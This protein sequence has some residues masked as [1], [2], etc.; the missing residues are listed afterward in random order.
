VG[1]RLIGATQIRPL[2]QEINLREDGYHFEWEFSVVASNRVNALCLPAGKV[3]VF[4]A[5]LGFVRSDD[6]L[7]TVLGHEMAHALAHHASERIARNPADFQALRVAGGRLGNLETSRRE[8][9]LQTLDAGAA[10]QELSYNRFQETEA[11]H[12]GVFLMTFAGYDPHAALAFWER[13][14]EASA[15]GIQLPEIL[16][17]HPADARRLAQLPEWI[18]LAEGAKRAYDQGQIAPETTR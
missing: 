11:D 7:A 8:S 16:S 3:I 14:R 15:G 10:L 17:D 18:P 9:I 5:L 13:M 1:N 6:E 4:S 12:I 2:M